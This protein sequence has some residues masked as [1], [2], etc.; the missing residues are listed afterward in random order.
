MKKLFTFLF[1]L[2][3][4]WL[5]LSAQITTNPNLV[6]LAEA[7]AHVGAD[8][9]TGVDVY[10]GS[11]NEKWYVFVDLYPN[12]GWE[13]DC[14]LH[15]IYKEKSNG[16]IMGYSSM[17]KTPPTDIVLIPA[18]TRSRTIGTP[19][20]VKVPSQN[21]G[22][23][24]MNTRTY[25]IVLSGGI[26]PA[27]N[28]ERYWN[29][30]SFI[31]QTLRNKYNIP[32]NNIYVA[33]SDGTDPG[34]D[35]NSFSKGFISSPL[36]LDFDGEADIEY[37]ATYQNVSNIFYELKNKMTADDHL[38]LF[39]IDHGGTAG[40]NRSYICL[41]N[42]EKL[43]DTQLASMIDMLPAGTVNIVLGQ[44]YSG[45]FIDNITKDGCVI[46]T[47]S[48]GS[49]SSWAC[50]NL[51]Y[52]EYVFHWTS[53]MAGQDAFRKPVNAD[54]DNDG[55][56]TAD[57]AFWYAE[58]KDTKNETPMYSSLPV[59]VGETLAF[60]KEP[61]VNTYDLIIRDNTEDTG[62]V[63]NLTTDIHWDSPDIWVRNQ[64][65]GVEAHENPYYSSDHTQAYVYVRIT[66]RG[67]QK[68]PAGEK[69][70]HVHWADASTAISSKAWTGH[71]E[72]NG[73]LTGY[74]MYPMNISRD[75]YPGESEVFVIP[76]QL[77]Q[78]VRETVSGNEHFCLLTE[79]TDNAVISERS[80]D[81]FGNRT[82]AQKNLTII[83]C[84]LNEDA[85]GDVF[86]R[87]LQ[88][89]ER[90]YTLEVRPRTVKDRELF[91]KSSVYMILSNKIK[92][93]W[94]SG[95]SQYSGASYSPS[96]PN[97]I[98]I[99]SHD[100][101]VKGIKLAG[102]E[103]EKVTMQFAFNMYS[104]NPEYGGSVSIL[105][106]MQNKYTF[107]LIQRDEL[108][109]EIV[110]GETFIV[111][112]PA[113]YGGVTVQPVSEDKGDHYTL[114]AIYPEDITDVEWTDAEGNLIGCSQSVDVVPASDNSE[115]TV[116]VRKGGV[117][118]K[119]N[120]SVDALQK[121]QSVNSDQSSDN[122][123]VVLKKAVEN[124][125]TYIEVKSVSGNSKPVTA[126]VA[127]G[128]SKTDIDVSAI[129]AGVVVISL[130]C[131]EKYI[132]NTKFMKK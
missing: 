48:T 80:F 33:M 68:Y 73:E 46:S 116:S 126:K 115:Y 50:G 12:R 61:E 89:T 77:P 58:E 27:S 18:I 5:T 2:M 109:G 94:Q 35:M 63:P 121:I 20:K 54:T 25:A 111:Y 74:F 91:N 28:Y 118:A 8:Q 101:K 17:V 47:A 108:T 113:S 78:V 104:P 70:L 81:V 21:N 39:V 59:S 107:D 51:L 96:V 83:D 106:Q 65:D 7:I 34:A 122:I 15:G 52:D 44:C 79:I 26:M 30:C 92:D 56:I 29:D 4:G 42:N 11:D 6:T 66:N 71:E 14:E 31:Y 62:R 124:D 93:A 64:K 13:H 49:E 57:E 105:P 110:G 72:Y 1:L 55:H 36:D 129:D 120:I 43:Y 85:T 40:N 32:K 100:A 127:H 19:L 95:G 45:G 87:N 84:T 130:K 114:S 67:T 88:D 41:W 60:D 76:W 90:S 24:T 132:D 117:M 112:S 22:N 128:D 23:N 125:N 119:A 86:V 102:E 131:D 97:R 3:V 9:K 69:Y 103:F 16:Y 37:A 53:A 75:I 99:N 98:N 38:F 10:V 123:E 82:I